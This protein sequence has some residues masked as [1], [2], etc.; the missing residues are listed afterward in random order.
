MCQARYFGE[1]GIPKPLE[2]GK[3][4]QDLSYHKGYL[5]SMG[6]GVKGVLFTSSKI[7]YNLR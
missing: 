5:E 7:R 4:L 2:S 1:R 3:Y 6:Y